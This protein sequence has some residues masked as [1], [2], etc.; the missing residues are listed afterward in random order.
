VQFGN[1]LVDAD[2][3]SNLL[4]SSDKHLRNWLSTFRASG[5]WEEFASKI[6]KRA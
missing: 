1:V 3:F 4:W 5:A 2:F 6:W